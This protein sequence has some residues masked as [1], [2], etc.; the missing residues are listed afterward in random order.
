MTK[1]MLTFVLLLCFILS[2]PMAVAG[3]HSLKGRSSIEL[4]IGFW[5]ESKVGNEISTA[6]NVSTAKSSGFIGG[7]S[8]GHWF[9]EG[10]SVNASIGLL[11]GE[12][13]SSVTLS[14]ASQRASSV[15]PILL[16]VRYYLPESSFG[17][18]V[19]PFLAAAVGPFLG[20]ESKNDF[21]SQES[22]SET[23]LGARL[24]G[25]IDFLLGQHFKLGTT[26]GYNLMT[27]FSSPI[28]ARKNFSGPEFT[29]GFGILFGGGEQ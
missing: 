9:Q 10:L 25:G 29:I 18:P 12:A 14:G 19:R 7:L 22:R 21:F 8:Y 11:S 6:G 23:A 24:G 5:H 15:I 3:D 1:S 27:D 17:T 4:N 20:V 26:V 28:G 13:T 2:V 16:G